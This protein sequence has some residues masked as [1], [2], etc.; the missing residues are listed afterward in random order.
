VL[1]ES[2][3]LALGWRLSHNLTMHISSSLY[4]SG[5]TR[6][7]TLEHHSDEPSSQCLHDVHMT[8][9]PEVKHEYV[10]G[11][12]GGGGGLLYPVP[13]S[14]PPPPLMYYCRPPVARQRRV[15][16]SYSTER[17]REA[18]KHQQRLQVDSALLAIITHE[19][20]TVN[21]VEYLLELSNQCVNTLIN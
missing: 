18:L 12:D 7:S 4:G 14:S 13:P 3:Y 8:S 6:A 20:Y 2:R 10:N 16:A 9:L 21:T 15:P 1:L 19:P 11:S 5:M 17:E